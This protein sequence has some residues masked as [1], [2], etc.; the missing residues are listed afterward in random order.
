MKKQS[1]QKAWLHVRARADEIQLD[2]RYDCVFGS[3]FLIHNL[4]LASKLR[5][6][7]LE[8]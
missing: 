6:V 2:R 3:N 7:E 4:S 8:T 1:K 5:L